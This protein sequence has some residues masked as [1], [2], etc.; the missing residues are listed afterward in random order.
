[1]IPVIFLTCS[2][3]NLKGVINVIIRS[4]IAFL[5][6]AGLSVSLLFAT[7]L[8]EKEETNPLIVGMELQYP[9]FEMSN[10]N[11]EPEGI[12]VGIA[13]AF[14]EYLGRPVE[15]Q[16]IEWTGLIP[17]L[18]TGSIDMVISSMTIT[19]E[20]AEQIDFS[21]PY[22]Q[23]GLT[24]LVSTSSDITGYGDLNQPGRV[25]AVKSGTTGAIIA[26]DQLSAAEVGYFDS[27]TAC[28]LEVSQGKADAFIYDALTVYENWKNNDETTR[29][30]LDA[31]PGT[32]GYW[33]AAFPKGSDLVSRF[34]TFLPTFR[35]N[36]GFDDLSEEYLGEIKATFDS[37]GVPF[38]F[39]LD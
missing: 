33:G 8:S 35:S 9:P 18:R 21:D 19:E 36:G 13:K 2:I 20:R 16:N 12:S 25:V 15:I 28:V 34:D 22:A 31:I 23:S 39:D 27:V 6:F 14:G 10:P 37:L 17:A 4:V 32:F 38:F 3:R 29:V 7:G 30:I 11:G 5:L 1:M 26:R 24:L